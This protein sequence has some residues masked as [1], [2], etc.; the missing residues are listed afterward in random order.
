[1]NSNI[2]SSFEDNCLFYRYL[3]DNN[4]ENLISLFIN[5]LDKQVISSDKVS[6]TNVS[7]LN[8]ALMILVLRSTDYFT[9]YIFPLIKFD[10]NNPLSLHTFF[11][12][13]LN[14]G[15]LELFLKKINK[16]IKELKIE[17]LWSNLLELLRVWKDFYNNVSRDTGSLEYNTRIKI[18]TWRK[19]VN[20]LL[21]DINNKCSITN[22]IK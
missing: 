3:Y 4:E 10:E 1:M 22:Y 18:D 13:Y 20:L 14:N 12:S 2:K 19:V 7:C 11:L 5:L 16:R 8:T 17:N 9:D 6:Q 21:S 15:K